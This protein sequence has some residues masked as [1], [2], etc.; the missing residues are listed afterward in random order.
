VQNVSYCKAKVVIV[1]KQLSYSFLYDSRIKCEKSII[2]PVLCTLV[3]S[4]VNKAQ[5]ENIFECRAVEKISTY[6][7][8]SDM[9]LTELHRGRIVIF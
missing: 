1:Y 6:E 7:G 5:F 4:T 8:I 9:K 2:V 3:C